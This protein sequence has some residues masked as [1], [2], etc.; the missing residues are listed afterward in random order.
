[1]RFLSTRAGLVTGILI[2]EATEYFTS[3]AYT[4]TFSITKAGK[5]GPATVIIQ[6][7]CPVFRPYDCQDE[8]PPVG[9]TSA[10]RCG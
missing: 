10:C 8:T 5:T 2:G 9:C 3:Y 7:R 4:P 6:V 1:M